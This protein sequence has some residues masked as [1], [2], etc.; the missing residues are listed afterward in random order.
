MKKV[1]LIGGAPTTGKS[2]I[3]QQLSKKLNL[4]WISTDQIRGMVRPYARRKDFPELVLPEGAETAESFLTKFSVEEI[5]DMELAQGKDVWPAVKY[6]IEEDFGWKE[7]VI[8]EGVN[9][10][11]DLVSEYKDAE[12]IHPIFLV[13][14]DADRMRHIVYTRGLWSSARNY[15]DELKPKEVE[16]AML[17]SKKLKESAKKFDFPCVEIEKGSDDLKR[18]IEILEI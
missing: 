4:P 6:L 14:E 16:W 1:I 2:T 11:P 5:A 10:T 9:I 7:G 18:V 3:A 17:F 13:D 8:I 12:N 15:S